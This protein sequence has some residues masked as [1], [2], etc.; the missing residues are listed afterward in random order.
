MRTEWFSPI[1]ATARV[2][3]VAD[4]VFSGLRV[5]CSN[6]VGCA[7]DMPLMSSFIWA[8][9]Q[10]IRAFQSRIWRAQDRSFEVVLVAY[11]AR[12]SFLR[13]FD[14]VRRLAGV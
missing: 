3:I 5:F 9:C 8:A 12:R 14:L 1:S 11:L 4:I 13:Q 6:F 10:T 2:S 7:F